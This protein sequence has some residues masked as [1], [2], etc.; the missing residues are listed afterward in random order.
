MNIYK[1]WILYVLF[2]PLPLVITL[3]ALLYVYDPYQLFH[4]PYFRE[5]AFFDNKRIQN[6]GIIK[7]QSFDSIIIGASILENTSILEANHKLGGTWINL[8]LPSATLSERN[9][10]LNYAFRYKKIKN[11][12]YSIDSFAM[13]NPEFQPID[14]TSYNFLYN[15]NFLDDFRPY[16]SRRF[17]M[18]ALTFSNEKKCI[19]EHKNLNYEPAWFNPNRFG[20]FYNWIIDTKTSPN[21]KNTLFN[22]ITSPIKFQ[23]PKTNNIQTQTNLINIF[24]VD[25]IKKNP[26]I[27]FYLV[28]PTY[29]RI[30]YKI[31]VSDV[32]PNQDGS[33][34]YKYSTIL[35]WLITE[36]QKYPNVKIYGF[37]TLNYADNLK[38]YSDSVHYDK[39]MNSMQLDAI[40]NGTH[41][42]TPQNMDEYFKI[43]EEKIRNYDLKPLI[44]QIKKAS[45]E[46]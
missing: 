21:D 27:N 30:H 28:I 10:F 22:A 4:K 24:L 15:S 12:I 32:Y 23:S 41:I 20:G 17:I 31:S 42:L 11:I 7:N 40:K 34:F 43:M 13:V 44:E 6:R 19:G 9:L 45:K 33:L 36:M 14:T 46:T 35:K 25:L 2:L 3:L 26:Q 38:N 1:K 18:C 5:K 16:F 29:P 37:D 8:S 39:S